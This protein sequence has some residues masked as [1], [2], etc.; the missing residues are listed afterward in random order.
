MTIAP[1]PGEEIAR[2]VEAALDIPPEIIARAKRI[3]D[4]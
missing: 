2:V 3:F 1:K 4:K